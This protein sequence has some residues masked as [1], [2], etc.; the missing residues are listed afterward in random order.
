MEKNIVTSFFWNFCKLHVLHYFQLYIHIFSYT[1][2]SLSILFNKFSNLISL[3][4]LNCSIYIFLG[5]Y[6]ETL[7]RIFLENYQVIISLQT[8]N[9]LRFHNRLYKYA[10]FETLASCVNPKLIIIY[11]ICFYIKIS[12]WRDLKVGW[13]CKYN[14]LSLIIMNSS[15]SITF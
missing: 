8:L 2:F 14:F 6:S 15:K 4:W 5:Y 11:D 1:H 7:K 12:S 13:L 10:T 9:Y 3:I